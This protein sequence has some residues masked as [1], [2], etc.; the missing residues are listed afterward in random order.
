MATWKQRNE[1]RTVAYFHALLIADTNLNSCPSCITASV[2]YKLGAKSRV[3]IL[4]RGSA[5]SAVL[6]S[7]HKAG[8]KKLFGREE[9]VNSRRLAG[10]L[11]G[12]MRFSLPVEIVGSRAMS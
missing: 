3:G 10:C 4:A 12:G 6:D 1:A 8:E 11:V 2:V 5:R 9:A 7:V